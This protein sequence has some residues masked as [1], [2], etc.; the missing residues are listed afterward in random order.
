[1][2]WF[3]ASQG[4]HHGPGDGAGT[5]VEF[6]IYKVTQA[7]ESQGNGSG[8]NHCI[9]TFPE[10]DVTTASEDEPRKYRAD[11]SAMKRHT[12]VPDSDYF[13]GMLQV[14]SV[15]G[16][17]VE[18]NVAEAGTEDKA[19]GQGKDEILE[20]SPYETQTAGPTLLADEKITRH[21]AEYVHESIP[22]QLK[23]A[24][25]DYVWIYLGVWQHSGCCL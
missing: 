22:A 1:M 5:A 24:N 23:R 4:K 13:Q 16:E 7:S 25:F 19:D 9:R 2:P 6:T 21:K 12:A 11:E 14:V 17:L 15:V 18:K 20:L 8:D 10:R 3:R